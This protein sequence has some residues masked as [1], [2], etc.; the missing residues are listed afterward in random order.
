MYVCVRPPFSAWAVDGW[1]IWG[2]FLINLCRIIHTAAPC[3]LLD[4]NRVLRASVFVE[5][6]SSVFA[7]VGKLQQ[8]FQTVGTPGGGG[9]LAENRPNDIIPGY[10]RDPDGGCRRGHQRR[11][12]VVLADCRVRG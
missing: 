2:S 9:R 10:P 11:H 6:A 5:L 12:R 4:P 3:R 1:K 8:P 7:G